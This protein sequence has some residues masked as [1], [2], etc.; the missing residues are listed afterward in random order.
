M[1][2]V[3][4]LGPPAA[5]ADWIVCWF[6]DHHDRVL[7]HSPA[8]QGSFAHVLRN[9]TIFEANVFMNGATASPETTCTAAASRADA[10]ARIAALERDARA[11]GEK[12]LEVPAQ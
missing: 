1:L 6:A 4:L 8:F 7:F 3:T 12:P 9:Q 2:A 10:E 11:T 5:R